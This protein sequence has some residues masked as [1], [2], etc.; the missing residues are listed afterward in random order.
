MSQPLIELI[1]ASKNYLNQSFSIIIEKGCK[2]IMTGGNG[3]GKTTLLLLMMGLIQPDRGKVIS[4][5]FKINYLPEKA[6]L[7]MHFMVYDY[8]RQISR[9][10]HVKIDRHLLNA[11]DIPY[12]QTI[13]TLSKGNM[14]KLCL[15]QA[16]IG[17][18][19][20][21]VLDE[22]LSGLDD[23]MSDKWINEIIG[24]Y[25]SSTMVIATHQKAWFKHPMFIHIEL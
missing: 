5:R 22:P 9:L 16:L 23:E 15:Y 13:D 14:Q 8:I 4:K 24:S 18:A 7:P 21:I 19:D 11:L 2:Y 3:S 25:P 20:L 10:K 6:E 17:D 12:D 1:E